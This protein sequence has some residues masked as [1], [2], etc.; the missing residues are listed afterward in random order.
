[1]RKK[2]KRK[3]ANAINP[4]TVAVAKATALPI[5]ERI[6]R[7]ANIHALIGS[8]HVIAVQNIG[9]ILWITNRAAE[10]E[11]L[12]PPEVS[13]IAGAASACGD[14]HAIPATLNQHRQSI[15]IGLQAVDRIYPKLK[16][17]NLLQAYAEIEHLLATTRGLNLSD[18]AVA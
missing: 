9:R 12:S 10:I 11:G 3:Y 2:T 6:K 4:M 16:K 14:V 1:V 8:D 17:D 15:I 7:E 13:I 18:F 5:L